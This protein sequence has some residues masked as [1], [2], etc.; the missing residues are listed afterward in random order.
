MR[1]ERAWLAKA[2]EEDN[3]GEAAHPALTLSGFTSAMCFLPFSSPLRLREAMAPEMGA[4]VELSPAAREGSWQSV[5]NY[6]D[7]PLVIVIP[8]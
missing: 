3:G 7:P 8:S 4:S 2:K 6:S 1:G 5:L